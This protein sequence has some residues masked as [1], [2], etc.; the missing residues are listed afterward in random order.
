MLASIP[1]IRGQFPLVPSRGG[2]R[3]RSQFLL[4]QSFVRTIHRRRLRERN[5]RLR[6]LFQIQQREPQPVLVPRVAAF[7]RFQQRRRGSEILHR[8]YVIF[9]LNID[10]SQ[11]AQRQSFLNRVLRLPLFFADALRLLRSV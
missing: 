10:L 8:L 7:V 11:R 1:T 2:G 4:R 3:R 5:L 6:R 9:F